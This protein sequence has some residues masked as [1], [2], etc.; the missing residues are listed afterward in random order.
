MM[1][2]HKESG[3][4][5]LPHPLRTVPLGTPGSLPRLPPTDPFRVSLRMDAACWERAR[6]GGARRGP[7]LPLP[8]DGA[9][10]PGFLRKRNE[11]E[12]QRG[13]CVN[14]GYA[15]LRDHLPRQTECNSDGE[16]KASSAPSPCSEPEDRGS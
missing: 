13:R 12:R 7:Y 15:R 4:L 8:L 6:A 1:E 14:E 3:L 10:E 5:A 11:R 9:L 2:K 16:S